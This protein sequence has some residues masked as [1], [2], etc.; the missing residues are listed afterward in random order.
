V[1]HAGVAYRQ[2][3]TTSEHRNA[4]SRWSITTDGTVLSQSGIITR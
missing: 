2:V 1:S 3:M 4:Q